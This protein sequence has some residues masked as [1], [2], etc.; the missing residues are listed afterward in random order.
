MKENSPKVVEDKKESTD[1]NI[2]KPKT[3]TVKPVGGLKELLS[4]ATN[5]NQKVKFFLL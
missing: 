2:V 4:G 1:N 3:E 5:E